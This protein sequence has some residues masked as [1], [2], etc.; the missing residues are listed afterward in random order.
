MNT[1][2]TLT[3]DVPEHLHSCLAS[4]LEEHAAWDYND[5]FAVALSRFLRESGSLTPAIAIASG[6]QS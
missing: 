6:S 3:V 5:V 4:F 2:I 1:Q